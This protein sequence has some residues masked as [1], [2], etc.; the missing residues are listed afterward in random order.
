MQTWK[1][2]QGSGFYGTTSTKRILR[3]IQPLFHHL[4][5]IITYTFSFFSSYLYC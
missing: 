4:K 1:S 5:K 2:G 3:I